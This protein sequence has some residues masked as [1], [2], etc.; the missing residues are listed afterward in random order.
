MK[1][2][3]F[4]NIKNLKMLK[5]FLLFIMLQSL[6]YINTKKLDSTSF[7]I[8]SEKECK[9]S[10]ESNGKYKVECT[11][12]CPNQFSHLCGKERCSVSRAT[13]EK[14]EYIYSFQNFFTKS[15]IHGEQAKKLFDFNIAIKKCPFKKRVWKTNQVCLNNAE[16]HNKN[17]VKIQHVN[18]VMLKKHICPCPTKYGFHCGKN[19]C[20][21]D[22]K[23][24]NDLYARKSQIVGLKKC[25]TNT[26]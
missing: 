5:N 11:N 7:C 3:S 2:E 18:F 13:C 23:A 8:V 19:H 10:Y 4:T 24:C 26:F 21:V 16:C 15:I 25:Q 6:Q 14:Y 9:G 22:A 20:A 1:K 17:V 12:S